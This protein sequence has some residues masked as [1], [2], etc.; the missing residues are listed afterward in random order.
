MSLHIQKKM[1]KSYIMSNIGWMLIKY[2][3]E[4]PLGNIHPRKHLMLIHERIGV[5]MFNVT[6][7]VVV[8]SRS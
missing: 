5:R 4:I 8:G 1:A 6:S 7:F 2:D 3:P